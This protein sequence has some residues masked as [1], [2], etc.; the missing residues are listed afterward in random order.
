M[1]SRLLPDD[2]G[3]VLINN[4]TS[5][6][7]GDYVIDY[8]ISQ[9]KETSFHDF[10][11]TIDTRKDSQ[12]FPKIIKDVYAFSNYGGGWLVLGVKENDHSD[13][14]I[15]GKFVKI[16]LPEDY[17]LEDSSLQEKIN[18]Y[19]DEPLS[20]RYT[21]FTRTI[22]DKKRRFALI[23]FPPSSKMMIPKKDIKYIA[24]SK[25]RTAVQKDIIYTRRGTQSIPASGLEKE[26]I[27]KRLEREEYRLSILSGEPEEIPEIIYSNL[28]QVKNI[29]DMIYLGITKYKTFNEVIK[30]L[31]SLHPREKYFPLKFSFYENKIVTFAN[32]ENPVNIHHEL[33]HSSKI[34]QE[35]VAD[36]LE[37]RDK[38]KIIISLLNKEIIDK[39]RREGLKYDH[40]TKKLFYTVQKEYE[41]RKEEWPSRYRGTQKKQVAKKIWTDKL[42]C[43]V[44]LHGAV[45]A[46]VMRIG[47]QF[48]LRLNPTMIITEDG[49]T[50][51]IGMREGAIITGQSYRI[52][53]K[54]QLNNILFWISKLGNG[55]NVLVIKDFK[56]SNEPVQTSMDIGISWD[57]PTM[58]FKQI[59]EEFA[60]STSAEE[61]AVEDEESA[62]EENYDC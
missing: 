13:D 53:N 62:E 15:K 45:R 27:N 5:D 38:E 14:K 42:N 41:K 35:S 59:I 33:V 19:L 4:E 47:N 28:F 8:L 46:T 50:P 48:Y 40:K 51:M 54:Q 23:Y 20:I 9:N 1:E 49:K 43:Y 52:Y 12:D 57:I 58:D 29:P 26:L 60:E 31:R 25:E 6:P 30:A 2:R 39:A 55:K 3:A 37:D 21:E 56:I 32:L 11:W 24:S 44:Y 34:T 18:S 17:D 36:W 61:N 10:K 7:I 22:N 16:G